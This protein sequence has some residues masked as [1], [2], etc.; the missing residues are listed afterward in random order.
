MCSRF[1]AP[2]LL[3]KI[4][5][6]YCI[7]YVQEYKVI[8]LSCILSFPLRSVFFKNG[9]LYSFPVTIDNRNQI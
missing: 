2:C 4:T 1:L 8:T 9:N 3:L 5:E 6:T 7:N